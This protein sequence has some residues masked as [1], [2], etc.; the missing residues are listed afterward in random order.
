MER[1][2]VKNCDQRY[3]FF[4]NRTSSVWNKLPK[5]IMSHQK[6]MDINMLHFHRPEIMIKLDLLG[7]INSNDQFIKF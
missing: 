1:Q 6:R 5:V 3:Y 4:T 7:N 2:L